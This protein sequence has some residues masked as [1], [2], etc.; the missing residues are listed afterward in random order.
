MANLE[1]KGRNCSR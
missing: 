1:G